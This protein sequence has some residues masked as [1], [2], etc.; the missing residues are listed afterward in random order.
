MV[1]L[2]PIWKNALNEYEFIKLIGVGS[3]G[4]VVHAKHRA[5][6]KEVAIKLINNLF[7]NS[8][9]S[10]KIVREVQILRQLAEMPDN[11]FTTK[12]YDIIAPSD[13]NDL[14]YIFIVMEYM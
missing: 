1:S 4:E 14:S 8:Y 11:D 5:S 6:G 13:P 10:K 12:I 7:K 9:D 2:S 3:Y